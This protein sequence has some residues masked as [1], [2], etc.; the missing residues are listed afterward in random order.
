MSSADQ[1]GAPTL[2]L[3]IEV[4]QR[5]LDSR[6]LLARMALERGYR[7]VIGQQWLMNAYLPQFN[8]GVV[9]YKGINNIQGGWM[10]QARRAGHRI[11]AINEEA[12]AL[13]MPSFIAKTTTPEAL[14]QIDRLCVQGPGER[15]AYLAHYPGIAEKL[16]LTGNPRADLLS[17]SRRPYH[18]PDR[19]QLR[20][21]HGRFILINTNFGYLNTEF[22][23]PEDF[24]RHCA[25][26]G[27]FNPHDPADIELFNARFAFERE[28]MMAFVEMPPVLRERFPDRKVILRPHPAEDHDRW[29]SLTARMDGVEVHGD[30]P[31]IPW[32]LASDLLIHNACTTGI[33][34]LL[35]EHPTIAYC[36]RA[37]AFEDVFLANQV[38]TRLTTLEDVLTS[39]ARAFEDPGGTGARQ[40]ASFAEALAAHYL[41]GFAPHAA[42]RVM[43]EINMLTAALS[44]GPLLRA[45]ES[46]DP[47]AAFPEQQKTRVSLTQA[48]LIARLEQ[49]TGKLAPGRGLT[50]ERLGESLFSI[51]AGPSASDQAIGPDALP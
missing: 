38:S 19:D 29:R 36:A 35:L 2:F 44:P 14:E 30:G 20:A 15:D 10:Q 22:G 43:R 5:E 42:D 34:G 26:L 16:A 32:I 45:G 39:A 47:N 3:M 21:A 7:V 4:A 13:A 46:L 9:L 31:A 49:V 37:N 17:A 48:Q 11:V 40:K 25:R 12:M 51:S 28:N 6:L 18:F 1:S 50:V 41:E 8:P 27:M 33:E 24:L 23:M